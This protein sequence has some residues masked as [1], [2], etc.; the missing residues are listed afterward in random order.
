[1][2]SPDAQ[3]RRA[4]EVGERL[5]AW[6]DELGLAQHLAEAGLPTFRRNCGGYAA[7]ADPN[8]GDP[9][10]L[11]QLEELD[12]LLHNEGDDPTYAVPV[13]LLQ[14]ARRARVREELLASSWLT[15]ETLAALRGAT[16]N[17]TR[18]AVH[19]GAETHQLLVVTTDEQVIVPAF[20]LD[21]DG[22]PRPELAQVLAPLLAA[23]MDPWH[24]WAWLTQPVALLGGGVPEK[25]AAVPGEV[26]VVRH[27]AVR[28]AEREARGT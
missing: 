15:Y 3:P 25:L 5:A 11:E 9:L 2:S 18:F 14:I 16:V 23:G 1:M 13:P 17:A 19:K 4:A 26:G 24:V 21:A 20:Q 8:T 12:A 27:A 22:R 7:W 10:S 28:L 6:L